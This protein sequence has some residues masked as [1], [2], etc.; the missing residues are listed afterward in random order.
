MFECVWPFWGIGAE[1][2]K[3]LMCLLEDIRQSHLWMSLCSFYI[4]LWKEVG[5]RYRGNKF[6]NNFNNKG[7][8]WLLSDLVYKKFIIWSIFQ[9]IVKPRPSL[10]DTVLFICSQVNNN[11]KKKALRKLTIFFSMQRIKT[12]ERRR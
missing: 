7:D 10:H 6:R 9:F 3:R 1:R 12:P 4:F 11:N 8:R 2:V 5:Q